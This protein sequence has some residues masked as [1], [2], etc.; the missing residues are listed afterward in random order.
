MSL[1]ENF[2]YSYDRGK[3]Y[4]IWLH[5]HPWSSRVRMYGVWVLGFRALEFRKFRGLKLY[6]AQ[7]R[8]RNVGFIEF[9]G[10]IIE[11]HHVSIAVLS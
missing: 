3:L 7:V 11:F 10:C 6:V 5:G 4:T 8:C 9:C 2:L 1:E